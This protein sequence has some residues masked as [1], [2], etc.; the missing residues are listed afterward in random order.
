M[1]H[2]TIHQAQ[3]QCG[4]LT[5]GEGASLHRPVILLT[6]LAIIPLG[7]PLYLLIFGTPW[8]DNGKGATIMTGRC[9]LTRQNG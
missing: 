9:N 8:E 5:I 4:A 2:C 1:L 3:K 6:P 7:V